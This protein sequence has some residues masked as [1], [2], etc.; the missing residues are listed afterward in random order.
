V[1]RKLGC[2]QMQGYLFSRPKPAGEIRP[3]LGVGG[4]K[5]RASA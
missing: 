4:D 5:V 2:T 3:L 1:L